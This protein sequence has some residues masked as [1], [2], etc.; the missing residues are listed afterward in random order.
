MNFSITAISTPTPAEIALTFDADLFQA[1][2]QAANKVKIKSTASGAS[3]IVASGTT[4]V[5][6]RGYAGKTMYYQSCGASFVLLKETGL[7]G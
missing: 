6:G 2:L 3:F 5:F 4:F 1:Q 7:V